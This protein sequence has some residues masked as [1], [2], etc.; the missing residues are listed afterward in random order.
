MVALQFRSILPVPVAQGPVLCPA[1][2]VE[3]L[4]TVFPGGLS[5]CQLSY[6]LL[7]CVLPSTYDLR[8]AQRY[9]RHPRVP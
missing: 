8:A 2:V 9:D 4:E 3:V 7:A 1:L 5:C 6:R